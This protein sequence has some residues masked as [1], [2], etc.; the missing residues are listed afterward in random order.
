MQS[1]RNADGTH[2]LVELNLQ[3]DKRPALLHD[4][5]RSNPVGRAYREGHG[6]RVRF[7]SRTGQL[8][9]GDALMKL[10]ADRATFAAAVMVCLMGNIDC[11]KDLESEQQGGTCGGKKPSRPLAYPPELSKSQ[12][13][14]SVQPPVP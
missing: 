14:A 7:K 13:C 3:G 5:D 6:W 10:G 9:I 12:H 11:R 2:S 1:V 4:V 8:E